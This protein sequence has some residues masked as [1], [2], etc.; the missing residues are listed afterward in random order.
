MLI[1]IP[2]IC[3]PDVASVGINYPNAVLRSGHTPVILPCCSDA[4]AVREMVSR[5][6]ALLLAGGGDLD[7]ATYGAEP[8]PHLGTVIRQRDDFEFFL[9]AQAMLQ[10]KPVL[11]IC[12]GIQ[13]I[14]VFFGGTLYQDLPSEFSEQSA[15][16]QRPD[17]QWDEVHPI[18]I[19]PDSRLA[20]VLG[21][22]ACS[23]NSTHHQACRQIASG[24]SVTAQAG[25]G[26]IEA[27][28]SEDY[29]ILGVQFHP[30]RLINLPDSAFLRLF[31]SLPYWK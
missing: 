24:F 11:G 20:Q 18:R 23:V 8:S 10:R 7:P 31:S 12:R 6:D 15:L 16:H 21:T 14:N 27:I 25:D 9:L 3:S 22:T 17:L 5:T 19:A 30:E 2:D 26:V 1:A 4:Q 29:P 13:V 28:E